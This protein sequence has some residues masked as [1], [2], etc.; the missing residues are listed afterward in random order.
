MGR[1][2]G[3]NLAIAALL[4]TAGCM[5][6]AEGWSGVTSDRT[7]FTGARSGSGRCVAT[8]SEPV[9]LAEGLRGPSA[10]GAD[11]Q[12]IY[13]AEGNVDGDRLLRLSKDGADRATLAPG[14]GIRAIALDDT[15]VYA[16]VYDNEGPVFSTLKSGASI[17]TLAKG[18][19]MTD[20]VLHRG[21]LFWIATG[22][23]TVVRL[24]GAH[25]T[26]TTLAGGRGWL[27]NVAA[28]AEYV[29]FSEGTGDDP[30]NLAKSELVRVPRSGGPTTVVFEGTN[31]DGVVADDEWVYFASA[32]GGPYPNALWRLP[33]DGHVAA[34][35]IADV[36]TST[37]SRLRIDGPCLY[38]L[39][40][41]GVHR[42]D[43]VGGEVATLGRLRD[44]DDFALD[45]GHVYV[46][47]YTGGR[48]Y[49]F[50]R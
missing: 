41:T 31:T 32:H 23:G 25:G 11:A 5:P 42:V 3:S 27:T 34:E 24:A 43:V 47:D 33:H 18:A 50:A 28:S 37:F 15:H 29:Y 48:L 9:V 16:V 6:T 8:E 39:S 38:F 4:A 2:E 21:D 17:A 1:I 26:P 10:V 19:R 13:L 7:S 30:A 20:L 45:E 36:P 12:S 46:T 40:A 35:V 14:A 49:A 44:A 22:T